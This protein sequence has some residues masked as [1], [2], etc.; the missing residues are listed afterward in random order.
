MRNVLAIL[1]FICGL[2]AALYLGIWWMIIQ[3]I[4]D[5]CAAF[6]AGNLTATLVGVT[7]LKVIFSSAVSSLVVY[8]TTALS[9]IVAKK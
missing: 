8:A 7:V 9:L 6:D 4:M 1:I 3:P 5:A 2:A